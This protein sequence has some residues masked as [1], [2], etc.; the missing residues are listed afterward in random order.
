MTSAAAPAVKGADCWCHRLPRRSKAHPGNSCRSSKS[1]WLRRR[2]IRGHRVQ[3]DRWFYGLGVAAGAQGA[4]VVV[5]PSRRREVARGG[6][7]WSE[8]KKRKAVEPPTATTI[9]IGG[10]RADGIGETSVA[11]GNRNRSP[12]ALTA[13]SLNSFVASSALTS[14]KGFEPKDSFSTSTWSTVTA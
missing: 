5:Q 6:V 11:A 10:W 12:P 1:H 2:R 8:H 14:G 4:D 3:P 7:V 9:R 13:A